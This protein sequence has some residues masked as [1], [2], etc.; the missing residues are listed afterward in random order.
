M[1]I[2]ICPGCSHKLRIPDGKRGT[3]TCPRCGAVWFH[4]ESIE[5]SDVE[6]RCSMSGAR[7][8]VISSRRS[9]LHKF[10]I[11]KIKKAAPETSCSSDA[12]PLSVSQPAFQAAAPSLALAAPKVGGWLARIM[13]RIEGGTPSVQRTTASN[14]QRE[15]TTTI[16]TATHNIDEYNWSGFSCPYCSASNFVACGGGHLACDGTAELRDGLRFHQ[17]FCGQAGFITGTMKTVEGKRVS[18]EAD[19]VAS[20]NSAV[21]EPQSQNRSTDIALPLPT[22]GRPPAKQ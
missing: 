14:E 6:F 15:D 3:V 22:Q 13:G 17:C 20:P 11:Q 1:A 10:V 4:P 16:P 12:G 2:V 7:F 9:P 8:N 5:L 18:V 21:P 19:V